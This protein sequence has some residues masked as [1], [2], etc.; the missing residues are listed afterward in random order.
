MKLLH[1]IKIITILFISSSLM[2]AQENIKDESRKPFLLNVNVVD[3]KGN[4]VKDLSKENFLLL[5]NSKPLEITYFSAEDSPLSVGFL[6][7]VSQSMGEGVDICREGIV[8]FLDGSNPKNEYFTIA[9][10]NKINLIS[11][12]SDLEETEKIISENPHFSKTPKPGETVLF[13]AVKLGLE[14]FSKAKNQKKV[15]FIFWDDSDHYDSG[16]YQKLER[17]VRENN[18]TVYSVGCSYID[19]ANSSSETDLSELSEISGGKS[20]THKD[21]NLFGQDIFKRQFTRIA[22]RFRNQYVIGFRSNEAANKWRKL[23]IK[24][25]LPEYLKKQAGNTSVIHRKGYYMVSDAVTV[26]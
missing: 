5:E 6:I 14:N 18:I 22:D 25:K 12:F 26:K 19:A 1:L 20:F 17:L 23:K 3:F 9:F 15:L 21:I 16:G 8:S 4:T 7:D 2:S 24:L 13:D 10:D 11:D